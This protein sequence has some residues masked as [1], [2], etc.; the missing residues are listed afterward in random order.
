MV[1]CKVILLGQT[2]LLCGFGVLTLE[3]WFFPLLSLHCTLNSSSADSQF[4]DFRFRGGHQDEGQKE[5]HWTIT[6]REKILKNA[7]NQSARYVLI[8][9]VVMATGF[10]PVSVPVKDHRRSFIMAASLNGLKV[11]EIYLA[12]LASMKWK[13]LWNGNHGESGVG[14]QWLMLI[15]LSLDVWLAHFA[16]SYLVL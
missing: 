1:S 4:S 16:L 14:S 5:N 11:Q 12:H 6:K 9:K 2:R 7:Q 15:K 3:T 13:P 10:F 8:T